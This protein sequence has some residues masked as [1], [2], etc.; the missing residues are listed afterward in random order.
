VACS[1]N[2]F[3]SRREI[4]ITYYERV[5]VCVCVWGVC[6]VCVWCAC[7][8]GVFGVCGVWCV[9]VALVIQHVKRMVR[10]VLSFLTRLALP[11]FLHHLINGTIFGRKKIYIEHK[12]CVVIS[13]TSLPEIFLILKLTQRDITINVLYIGLHVQYPLFFLGANDA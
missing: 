7:V 11:Y 6:G 8:C 9:C 10:I 2:R 3:C 4:C 13:S 5:C 12:M 1:C